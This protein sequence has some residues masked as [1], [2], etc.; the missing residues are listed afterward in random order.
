QVGTGSGVMQPGRDHWPSAMSIL[1]SGGGLH[2][3]QVIGST[4]SKGE[5][6]K[7]RPLRPSD[8]MATVYGFLGVDQ[9][10]E[11]LD[12]TGRPLPILENGEPIREL[13]G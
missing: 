11:F 8:L 1:V 10:R 3:G 2:M 9:H 12:H 4:T 13:V 7:D 6:P 5:T